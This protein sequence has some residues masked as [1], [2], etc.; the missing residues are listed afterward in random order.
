MV[1]GVEWFLEL[2]CL[3]LVSLKLKT[4]ILDEWQ[5]LLDV[6]CVDWS[7]FSGYGNDEWNTYWK[8][9][10]YIRTIRSQALEAICR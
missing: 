4:M 9:R 7:L 8:V 5:G 10:I 6:E 1:W 3:V 2:V